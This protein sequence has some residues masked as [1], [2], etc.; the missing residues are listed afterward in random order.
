[1]FRALTAVKEP[2]ATGTLL[3]IL[4]RGSPQVRE[5]ILRPFQSLLLQNG[6]GRLYH[7]VSALKILT[8]LGVVRCVNQA[9]NNLAWNNWTLRRP[10]N[11]F[12]FGPAKEELIII[13]G[14]SSGFGYEMVKGFSSHA[15]IVVLDVQPFPSELASC[16]FMFLK[17]ME[18]RLT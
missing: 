12:N 17:A 2:I 7:F 8:G 13:T 9:L 10:G 6:P 5:Y 3:Y 15:R 4:T 18:Y 14:G 1:M 11:P 16:K